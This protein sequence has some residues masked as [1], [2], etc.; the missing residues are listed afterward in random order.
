MERAYT[1]AER[2]EKLER[3]NRRMKLTGCSVLLTA[4]ALLLMGQTRPQAV[5]NEL[6]ARSFVVVD[7][8][9]KARA[10]LKMATTGEPALFLN[11]TTETARVMLYG[12]DSGA[13]LSL[14][15]GAGKIATLD[16]TSKAGP[17]LFLSGR[18]EPGR[19]ALAILTVPADGPSLELDD[20]NGFA[21]Q[22]GIAKLMTT[23]TGESH[24]TSA[25]SIVLLGKDQ[26]V[27][28]SAP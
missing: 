27:L 1:L 2:I 24:Q 17:R 10:E 21:T 15:G 16:V 11:D 13:G 26:K 12:S 8:N 3:Q 5:R 28:W 14:F 4:A 6:R 22:I 20:P 9:G 7:A 25:A 18:A 23:S 19:I